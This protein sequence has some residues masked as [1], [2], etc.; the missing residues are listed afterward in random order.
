MLR[1]RGKVQHKGFPS[2]ARVAQHGNKRI[3]KTARPTALQI[4]IRCSS[5]SFRF[6]R[7]FPLLIFKSL[8]FFTF[9]L[10]S[11]SSH[12]TVSLLTQYHSSLPYISTPQISICSTF[13][14]AQ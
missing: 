1:R 6:P 4:S 5:S 7:I 14:P 8:P 2:V 11:A 13:L 10:C 3:P 9:V 12:P